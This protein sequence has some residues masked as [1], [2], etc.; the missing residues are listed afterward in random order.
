MGTLLGVQIW[1]AETYMFDRIPNT[2]NPREVAVI[3]AV[4]VLSSLIGA[5]VPAWR[6]ASL[7]PV[8]ALRFE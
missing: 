8:D 3:V 4:A 5:A 6:A 7:R 2:M 1:T